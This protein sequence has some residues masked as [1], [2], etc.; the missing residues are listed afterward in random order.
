[1]WLDVNL[2]SSY[3]SFWPILSRG[4]DFFQQLVAQAYYNRR[5]H[6][7][8]NFVSTSVATNPTSVCGSLTREF[9]SPG[10]QVIERQHHC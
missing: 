4:V 2:I 9:S 7:S 5:E 8:L 10:C 6:T 1:M 3:F